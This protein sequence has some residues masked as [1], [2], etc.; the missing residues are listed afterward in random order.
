M[1]K[2]ALPPKLAAYFAD[3]IRK[4][5]KA[6][7][8]GEPCHTAAAHG[9]LIRSVRTH[10]RDLALALVRGRGAD[11]PDGRI[12]IEVGIHPNFED[13]ALADG[14]PT[15]LVTYSPRTGEWTSDTAASTRRDL[16]DLVAHIWRVQGLDKD[17]L[18]EGTATRLFALLGAACLRWLEAER[19]R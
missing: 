6:G 1:S 19:S 18:N 13:K 11:L 15:M 10:E 7:H 14:R 8:R 5:A 2:D 17:S 9:R 4:A 16:L 3:E 12:L